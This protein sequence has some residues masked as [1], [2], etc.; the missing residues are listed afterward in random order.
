MSMTTVPASPACDHRV[1]GETIV[2]P[3]QSPR[4]TEL[5][6]LGWAVVAR[7]FGAQL[8][9]E[10]IDEQRLRALVVGAPGSVRALAAA[11]VDAV[12]ALDRATI[13]DYPGSVATQHEPLD[14]AGATPSAARRA[15]GA[16]LT[17]GELVAM[18]F[19]SVDGAEA[20]TD[21][22][23]VDRTQRGRG[24]GVAVKAAS[25]LELSAAGVTRFR[26]GGSADNAAIQRANVALGYVR[27]EEWVTLGRVGG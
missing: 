2:L 23:V 1:M 21:F 12:L 15:F 26:T 6:A 3:A 5:E 11:D 27:D 18:T 13:G 9:A 14:R 24:L 19:V 20:E 16:F 22:T 4:R 7:S 8:D 17:D 10:R 25:V